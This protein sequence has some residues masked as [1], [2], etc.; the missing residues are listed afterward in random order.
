MNVVE[1]I[2]S[3][4]SSDKISELVYSENHVT[5]LKTNAIEYSSKYDSINLH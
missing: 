1:Q 4:P 5:I 3:I 2:R